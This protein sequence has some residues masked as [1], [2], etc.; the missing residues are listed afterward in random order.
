MICSKCHY[1]GRPAKNL[2]GTPAM[3][4]MAWFIFPIGVPYTLWR[5]FH[6][7]TVC[8]QCGEH[9]LIDGESPVGLRLMEEIIANEAS[10]DK[11][12]RTL[13]KDPKTW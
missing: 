6:K 2:R 12:M 3:A 13:N 4:K 10:P 5:M 7:K 11:Q 8:K 1:F 9:E